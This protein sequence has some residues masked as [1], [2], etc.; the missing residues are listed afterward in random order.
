[1]SSPSGE[2]QANP[3]FCD[4]LGYTAGDLRRL[5]LRDIT[6]PEDWA[7]TARIMN[8]LLA[9]RVPS[10]R[11]VGRFL[12]KDGKSIWA[13]VSTVL[14][15]DDKGRPLHFFTTIYDITDRI[16]AEEA[17]MAS[18][19]RFHVLFEAMKEIVVLHEEVRDAAGR[20]VDYRIVDCNRAFEEIAGMSRDR[21][22]NRLASDFYGSDPPPY[23]DRYA[24]VL[25]RERPAFFEAFSAPMGRHFSVSA[26]VFSPGRFAT[27]STDITERKKMENRLREDEAKYRTLFESADDAIQLMRGDVFIDCN[28]RSLRMFG[29]SGKEEF[30]GR[31]PWEFSPPVQPDGRA[32]KDKARDLIAAAKAGAPQRFTWRHCRLDGSP[33][34]AEVSLNSLTLGN[35]VYLQAIVRDIGDRKTHEEEIQRALKEKE[36]LIREVYHRTKNNMNVIGAMLS[37]RARAL[38]DP[39]IADIFHEIVDRIW[40]MALVH[41]KLYES[42]DLHRI[43]LREYISDLAG[44]LTG[45]HKATGIPVSVKLDLEEIP[46]PIDAAIPCGMILNELFSNVF[47][48]AFPG[49]GAGE[50]RIRLARAGDGAVELD[51]RDNGIGLPPGFDFRN[52]TSLGFQTLVMLVEHQLLGEIAFGA[53]RGCAC[54]IRFPLPRG[55]EGGHE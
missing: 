44:Q 50:V 16:E 41:K 53:D 46:V 37:L 52:Q 51:F 10:A 7:E 6:H 39:R 26:F 42:G 45:S 12:R 13:D 29:C 24:E 25:E 55:H 18:E 17:L 3:A 38:G 21:V 40:G 5:N 15:R 43:D 14:R 19:R 27:V 54:R 11:S 36:T 31:P 28:E 30:I 1:M 8:E 35:E 20:M 22:R 48:H 2:I 34:E 9:G 4:M 47:K 32:S 23:L 33:L 49:G